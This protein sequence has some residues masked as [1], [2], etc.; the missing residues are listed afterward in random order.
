AAAAGCLLLS[1]CGQEKAEA[2]ATAAYEV[3]VSNERSDDVS[4]IDGATGEIVSTFAVGKRPRGLNLSA[5]GHTLYVAVS[6]SPIAGP[7]VDESTLPPADKTA[8]GIAV[9]D[10]ASHKVRTV[11]RGVSDPEQ[12]AATPDGRLFIASEDTG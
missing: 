3:Y 6:G 5:D 12:V 1:A 11:V 8:D 4:V 7:G 10:I 9:V 2:P